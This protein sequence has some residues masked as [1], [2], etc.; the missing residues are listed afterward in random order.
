MGRSHFQLNTTPTIVKSKN[1]AIHGEFTLLT[2]TDGRK[3]GLNPI[4]I[5]GVVVDFVEMY[6][7]RYRHYQ[8]TSATRTRLLNCPSQIAVLQCPQLCLKHHPIPS[9]SSTASE[10]S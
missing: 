2:V 6:L 7:V 10:G 1:L 3:V 9:F 4:N 5:R 8:V